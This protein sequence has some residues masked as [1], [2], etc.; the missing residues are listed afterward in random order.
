MNTGIRRFILRLAV[1]LLAF[2]LG[3]AVAWALGG[4]NPFQSSSDTRSY[5]KHCGHYRSWSSTEHTVY[6]EA[7][8]RNI[9]SEG[10]SC[11][12]KRM[13]GAIPPPPPP[14]PVEAAD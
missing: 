9:G 7:D 8:V 2:L 13:Y 6:P 12:T 5:R 4:L 1:G 3:V 14:P 10:R 11:K